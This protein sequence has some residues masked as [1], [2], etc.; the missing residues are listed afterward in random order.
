[1]PEYKAL[2]MDE[3]AV[4][5]ALKRISHEILEHN[6]GC[7]NLCIIGIS[8]RGVPIAERISANIT[9]IEG[10]QLDT[11]E[12]DITSYRDDLSHSQRDP[13]IV[14]SQIP[15]DITGRRVILVD[16]V[17]YTG[18]TVRAALD[19]LMNMGRA[20]CIQ[21]AVLIDRGHRELPI[22][23]DYVGKNIPTSLAEHI[24]VNMPPFEDEISVKLY[25]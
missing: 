5:R 23:G 17:L 13:V 20:A 19:A 22:R 1:M 21:L 12:V 15:F 7:E 2:L 8:R 14:S 16:D 3:A 11:G 24:A 18:R 25:G 6:N 9:A 10:R 4:N